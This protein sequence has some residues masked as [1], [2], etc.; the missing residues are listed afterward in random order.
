MDPERWR[1]AEDLFQAALQ[2]SAAN[3]SEFLA[4][5]CVGDDELLQFVTRLLTAHQKA[6]AFLSSA[7]TLNARH[8]IA[9]LLPA[10][11]SQPTLPSY[12]AGQSFTG[13]DRFV[14]R[15]LLGSGGM[16]VVYEALD[17]VRAE[18]LALKTLKQARP[19]ELVRLKQEFRSLAD[20]AHP[21]LASL[22]ELFVDDAVCFFTMELV[23]G[24]DFIDF[25]G[26]GGLRDARPRGE[27][28]RDAL[29]QLV[30]GV[31]HLHEHGKLHRD[32]KPSNVLVAQNGR[33]VILD[34]G[35]SSDLI[36]GSMDA[37]EPMAGTPAY[38]AP[39]RHAWAAPTAAQDWYSVGVTL[40]QA[41]TSRLPFSG[42]PVDV[43]KQQRESG[44]VPPCEISD[45]V[46]RDLNDICMGLLHRDPS[47]RFTEADIHK[48]LGTAPVLAPRGPVPGGAATFVG[49]H[50]QLALLTDTWHMARREGRGVTVYVHGPSGIGKTAFLEAFLESLG[51][52]SGTIV[53]EG[54]CYEQESV[55][56]KG[57]DGVVDGLARHLRALPRPQLRGL[58]PADT[59]ALTRIFPVLAGLDSTSASGEAEGD[60]LTVRQRAFAAL[61]ELLARMSSRHAVVI[62]IDDF[63]WS[64]ADTAALLA[65]LLRRPAAPPMLMVVCARPEEVAAR[66]HLAALF[67]DG[68]DHVTLPLP[69]LSEPDARALITSMAGTAA[70]SDEDVSVIASEAEGNP[71][72]LGQ[73]ARHASRAAAGRAREASLASV[74]LE[75][76]RELPADAGDF[77]QMLALCGRPMPPGL[78]FEASG[79]APGAR[80]LLHRLR[81][82]RFVRS[83]GSA[84]QVEI[85]H[86]R[87]QQTIRASIPADRKRLLHG[88]MARTLSDQPDADPE[89][90]Y[91]HYRG[92]GEEEIAGPYAAAAARKADAALAFD[93]AAGYYRDALDLSPWNV[94]AMEWR[95]G[96]GAALANAGRPLASA[97]VYL[98]IARTGD[99]PRRL[100][101]HRRAAEQLLIG[102][103][104]DRGLETLGTVLRAVGVRLPATPRRTLASLA[105]R[106]AQLGWRGLDYTERAADRISPEALVRIDTCWSAASGLALVDSVRAAYF[107]TRALLLALD[108]G[109]PSRVV[110]G[111][112]AEVGFLASSGGRTSGATVALSQR[113]RALSM[114]IGSPH[115]TALTDLASGVAAFMLGNWCEAT[116]HC[117]QALDRLRGLSGTAWEAALAQNFVIG[118]LS[119]EGQLRRV[120]TLARQ[121]LATARDRGHTYW[122]TELRTRQTLVWLAQDAPEEAVRQADEGIAQWSHAGFHRQHY[123]HVLA[124]MQV[125]I[126]RG[127]AQAAWERL[128]THWT[129]IRRSLLLRVQWTRIEARYGRARCALLMA[130]SGRRPETFLSIARHEAARIRHER[131]SWSD[132]IADLIDA[133]VAVQRGEAA[134][135]RR[136]L[137]GAIESFDRKGMSLYAAATRRR[138]GALVGGSDGRDYLRQSDEFMGREEIVNPAHMTRLIA[139]G[140]DDPMD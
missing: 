25:V 83:R 73:L 27:R 54:R 100:E 81:A 7:A 138:L 135:A 126:Y 129:A 118:A 131:M 66:P 112:A 11:D 79:L 2:C 8:M 130:R 60:P 36:S 26:T 58:L 104:I 120:T 132:P 139:P 92:A 108:A 59:A 35:L 116:Q 121:L 63:H 10:I 94:A 111:L 119:Y 41:L 87:I 140:F 47:R 117:Q 43:A 1:R 89:A 106:R 91:E 85:Y 123:N 90:L 72:L 67:A 56:Y 33:V 31:A 82:T 96:L 53:L 28:A 15:R 78:V 137:P 107:Q 29:R 50:E 76:L 57:L 71:F 34:F 24:T 124:H 64:D 18:R 133:G 109:E 20:I 48:A 125:A 65:E 114:K 115:A 51:P 102:G 61:R 22:Y 30:D 88:R 80:M 23:E 6:G 113:A 86:D 70:V 98:E 19:R 62:C 46:P 52:H 5:A 95:Q 13:T 77:L 9:S 49:R 136:L 14:V 12:Q 55:P 110:R 122:D 4:H 68:G 44:P 75:P 74:L 21:N 101:F 84:D 97:D 105:A 3:R 134:A 103:H 37:A 17:R 42:P 69:S 40:Y 127:D 39:E 32:I 45:D 16:G 38:F 128:S 93:R 99:G